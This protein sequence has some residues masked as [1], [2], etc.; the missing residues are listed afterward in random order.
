MNFENSKTSEHHVLLLDLTDDL[1][2]RR[3]KKLWHYQISV[4]I[5]RGKI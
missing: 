2:L 5:I 1:D 4:F 3:G